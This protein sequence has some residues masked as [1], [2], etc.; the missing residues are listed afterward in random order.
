MINKLIV[1]FLIFAGFILFPAEKIFSQ[2]DTLAQKQVYSYPNGSIASTGNIVNGV[3]HGVW[4]TFYPNG[5]IKSRGEWSNGLLNGYWEFFDSNGNVEKTL[6]FLEGKKHGISIEYQTIYKKG[7]YKNLAKTKELFEFDKREGKSFYFSADGYIHN[8]IPFIHDKKQGTG[9]TLNS[10]SIATEINY[11]RN[12]KLVEKETVNRTDSLGRKQGKWIVLNKNFDISEETNY[13]NSVLNG[14]YRI[15]KLNGDVTI[16]A[17]YVNGEIERKPEYSSFDFLEYTDSIGNEMKGTFFGKIPIG[18]HVKIA[19]NIDSCVEYNSKG[20]LIGK[21]KCQQN[22]TKESSWNLL[23]PTGSLKAEGFYSNGLKNSLWKF[24]YTNGKL[25]Q[26][27]VY[28]NGREHGEWNWY[29]QNGAIRKTENYYYGVKEGNYFEYDSLGN[30]LVKGYFT[31]N[32]EDGEWEVKI[33]DIVWKGFYIFGELSGKVISYFTNNG[34]KF[35]EGE[36]LNGYQVG[37][38][39]YYYEDGTLKEEQ[40]WESGVPAGTWKKFASDGTVSITITY[41]EGK[42]YLI[43]GIRLK[44]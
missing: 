5:K 17:Y 28:N 36:F 39:R 26:L 22:G 4:E 38:H 40:I 41:R 43:N 18:I 37:K 44:Y 2:T 9:F 20:K 8:I 11:Y 12:N 29:F 15:F 24:Y 14:W 31:E 1:G 10:D 30:T 23:F 25:E 13:K 6:T 35:F 7:E 16:Q 33:G 42:E 27:G 19:E 21:G 3:P 32:M 34:N